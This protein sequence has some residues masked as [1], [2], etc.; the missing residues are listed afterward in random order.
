MRVGLEFLAHIGVGVFACC[1]GCFAAFHD[2]AEAL[3]EL[4][5]DLL[6][7][8]EV[9]LWVVLEELQLLVAVCCASVAARWLC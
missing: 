4:V 8:F 6:A 9:F 5:F 2:E 7:V 3:V 1:A